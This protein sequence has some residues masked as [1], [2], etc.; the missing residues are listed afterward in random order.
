MKPLPHPFTA[1][2]TAESFSNTGFLLTAWV[3]SG[4]TLMP[5]QPA[6]AHSQ[7]TATDAV[8]AFARSCSPITFS[9]PTPNCGVMR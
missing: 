1:D 5:K 4:V 9:T 8:K 2:E 6:K 7:R 3:Y